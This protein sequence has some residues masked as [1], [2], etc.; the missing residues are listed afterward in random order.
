MFLS[1]TEVPYK[2]EILINANDIVTAEQLLHDSIAYLYEEVIPYK[3]KFP[4]DRPENVMRLVLRTGD[5]HY[6]ELHPTHFK[7]MV[8]NLK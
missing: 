5:T 4:E 3:G 1:F 8:A 6:V 2:N 7:Q